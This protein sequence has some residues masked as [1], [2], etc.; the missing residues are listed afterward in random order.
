MTAILDLHEL[1]DLIIPRGGN[2]LV[3]YIMNNTK[4]PVMGHAD[5]I[6]HVFVDQDA[7]LE[8][9]RRIALDA[10]T[11]YVS[12]CNAMETLLIHRDI[13]DDFV[14]EMMKVYREAGVE[15][16][17]DETVVKLGGDGVVQ[18]TDE[19]WATEYLEP[20][21]SV[22]VVDDVQAAVDHINRYSSHHTDAIV[23]ENKATAL[24]FLKAVDSASVMHN[25]STRFA[26][27][28]RYGLGAEVGISTN[29]L[30]SR[31]PVGLEGLV[32]YKYIVEGN[33]QIVGDY[34]GEGGR[35]FTHR[36]LDAV[37]QSAE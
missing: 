2:D 17:G 9:A 15:V 6:C 32:I 36:K 30:H 7:D 18:A 8:K 25:A 26:D 10:K 16:R 28:F 14:P 27:G 12:V 13:A 5:G 21:L 31:G 23:T 3:Q 20:I 24:H 11:Q 4:I 22:K 19:D 34:S 37:W 35:S 33:G 29:R 1:I